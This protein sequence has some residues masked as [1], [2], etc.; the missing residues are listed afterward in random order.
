MAVATT[1]NT[2]NATC[3]NA[4]Q[5]FTVPSSGVYEITAVGA[6]GGAA[7]YSGGTTYLGGRASGEFTLTQ[8][9][10]LE[11][12]ARLPLSTAQSG[13]WFAM[14]NGMRGALVNAGYNDIDG[15]L[16]VP[17]LID[18]ICRSLRESEA[19]QVS[20]GTNDTGPFQLLAPAR[21]FEVNY[22]DFSG[23]SNPLDAAVVW[24]E[25]RATRTFDVTQ[26]PLFENAVLKISEHRHLWFHCAHHIVMDGFGFQLFARRAAQIYTSLV[27]DREPVAC[28]FGTLAALVE[29]DAAYQGSAQFERDRAF[30]RQKSQQFPPL[31]GL[32]ERR[33]DFS[34]MDLRCSGRVSGG[35]SATF[36]K[37]ARA[38]RAAR[39]TS[40]WLHRSLPWRVWS[41]RLT[42]SSTFR[43]WAVL[44]AWPGAPQA[45][46]RQCC[47]CMCRSHGKQAWA[48]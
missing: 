14:Q 35:L 11:V 17:I 48:V 4:I 9:E 44:A 2:T 1:G 7:T 34:Q 36:D 3:G 10:V 23:C 46:A 16:Q 5:S 15:D 19:V 18:A 43:C 12:Q 28:R 45:C 39:R 37:V 40:S 47:R 33:S 27:E 8:G 21:P 29:E 24:M 42:L 32:V 41:A 26:F 13:L 6:Q 31:R 30:W 22:L 20:V 38:Q 25:K